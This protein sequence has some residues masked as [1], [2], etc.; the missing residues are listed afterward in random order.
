[1]IIDRARG[2]FTA[3]ELGC[4]HCGT[5]R[6]EESFLDAL[7]DIRELTM[8]LPLIS[9]CRCQKHNRETVKG[10]EHSLHLIDNPKHLVCTIAADVNVHDWEGYEKM[11]FYKA[12]HSLGLSMGL[13]NNTIHVDKRELAGLPQ[14]TFFYGYNPEWFA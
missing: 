10:H 14:V 2:N 3:Q 6:V 8:P 7:E 13:K 4:H 5:I 12:A 9:C 11:E 1:M